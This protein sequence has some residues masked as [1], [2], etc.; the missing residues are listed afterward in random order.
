MSPDEF[1]RFLGDE[2]ASAILRTP[3]PERAIPAMEAAARAGFRVLE[4]TL[5]IP[6]AL[7][8]I[9]AFAGRPGLAIGAGTVLS[10]EQARE[11]YSAGARFLVS[12][13][14]DEEVISAAAELGIAAIPGCATPTEMLRARRAGAPLVKLFPA[15]ADVAAWVRAVL[16]PLPG[17]KIV[18]TNGVDAGNAAE[19]LAAGAHAIGFVSPL[20]DP[21]EVAAGRFDRVEE[22]GRALLAAVRGETKVE[23]GKSGG[24][25]RSGG[26]G[27]ARSGGAR[28]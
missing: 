25:G 8:A 11:A 2:R 18:P 6:G 22:R 20:F 26:R 16:G 21:E 28:R 17:L 9:A 7:E 13:V 19:V 3:H 12:P 1:V 5:T 14:V 15:P 4:F 24:K 10:R 23:V 27:G